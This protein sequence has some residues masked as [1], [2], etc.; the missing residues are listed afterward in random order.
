MVRYSLHM[1]PAG[2]AQ[3]AN[4][5][6]YADLYDRITAGKLKGQLPSRMALADEYDVAP[7]TVHRAIVRLKEDGLVYSVPGLGVFVTE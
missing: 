4:E 2:R 5:R 6:V 3:W 1:S 7:M